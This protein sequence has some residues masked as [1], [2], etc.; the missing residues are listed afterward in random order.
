MANDPTALPSK[1]LPDRTL[2]LW[3]LDRMQDSEE[4]LAEIQAA[5]KDRKAR[6]ARRS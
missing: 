5:R 6:R 1:D 3:M 2:A 4:F